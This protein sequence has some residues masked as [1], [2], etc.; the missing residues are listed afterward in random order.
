[1]HVLL[2]LRLPPAPSRNEYATY[3]LV[4]TFQSHPSLLECQI[5]EPSDLGSS[6]VSGLAA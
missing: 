3:F 2:T 6:A 1:M 5:A 4:P